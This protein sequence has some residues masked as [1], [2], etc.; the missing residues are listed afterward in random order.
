MLIG[1]TEE[2]EALMVKSWNLMKNNVGEI[3]EIAPLAKKLFSFLKDS[4]TCESVVQHRKGG[5]V[6]VRDSTLKKLGVIKFALL[7][8]LKEAVPKMWSPAS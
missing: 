7:E 5:K 4:K 3:F 6:T 2:Q 8:T 1:F